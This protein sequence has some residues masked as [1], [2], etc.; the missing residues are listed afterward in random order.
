[1]LWNQTRDGAQV[2][3][4]EAGEWLRSQRQYWRIT[5]AELAEQAGNG[6]VSLTDGIE[7]G[8]LEL[9]RFMHAAIA[10]AFSLDRD[11]LANNCEKRYG[12]ETAAA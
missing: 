1:M 4:R 5:Q 11:A 12:R 6:D 2:R 7:Q 8:K 9:P 10:R 3:Y